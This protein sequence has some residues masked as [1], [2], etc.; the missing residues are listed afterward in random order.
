[1]SDLSLNATGRLTDAL[2][3][4]LL[5][6]AMENPSSPRAQD[7]LKSTVTGI[8]RAIGN[9]FAFFDE[10]HETMNQARAQSARVTG[11]HW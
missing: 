5:R 7:V 1:M 3:R 6:G 11:S 8:A 4:D 2:E 10:V 9:L